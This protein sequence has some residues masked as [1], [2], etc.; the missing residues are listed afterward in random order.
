M[1]ARMA[2]LPHPSSLG[3]PPTPAEAAELV[4]EAAA[5]G[6]ARHAHIA[7]R[8]AIS[9]AHVSTL[10]RRAKDHGLLGDDDVRTIR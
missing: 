10:I 6:V 8:L 7:T 5:L 9:A 4:R 3:L 1:S 2:H